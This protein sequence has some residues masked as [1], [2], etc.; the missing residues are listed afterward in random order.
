MNLQPAS[1]TRTSTRTAGRTRVLVRCTILVAWA[2]HFALGAAQAQTLV[3]DEV[4]GLRLPRNVV[5]LSYE[6][7]LTID[8]KAETF[9][10]A[11]AIKVRVDKPTDL[12]WLNAAKLTI[13]EARAVLP[14]PNA[15]GFA[16][17]VV[18]GN[19]S[20]IGLKFAQPLP[21]GEATLRIR[22]TGTFQTTSVNG[23]F[24]QK[25]RDDWYIFTHFEPLDARRA[26]PSFD[27]PDLKASWKLTLLIPEGLRAFANMPV[28]SERGSAPGWRE[29]SFLRSPPLPTY[30]IAFAVGSFDVRD[31]GTAGMNR[32]PISVITPKGRAA[33]AAYAAANTGAILAAAEKY[34][35][36]PYPFPKLDL[37]AFPQSTF[38][39]AMENAG[40][41]TYGARGLLARPDEMSTTFEQW[42]IAVT[43]HEIAHMWFGDLVTMAWWDDLWLNESFASWLG[44]RITAELKPAW[45]WNARLA[46]TRSWA[47]ATDRLTSARQVRQP[48]TEVNEVRAAFDSITYSKGQSVLTMFEDWLGPENFRDGV[49]RYLAQHE[50][51]NATADDFFVALGS[52]D[53]ALIPAFRGFVD[54][55]GIPLLDVVLNC[56][57]AP[58]IELSQQRLAP[59]GVAPMAAEPWVFPVCFEYGGAQKGIRQCALVRDARQSIP[60]KV[61]TCPQWVVANRDS[62]GYYLPRLSPALYA[63]LPKAERALGTKG[64]ASLIADTNTLARAGALGYVDALTFG[65]RHAGANEPRIALAAL[66]IAADLPAEFVAPVNAANFAAWVRKH[67][68]ARAKSVGWLPRKGEP[69]DMPELR[70]AALP[71]VAD[72][73]RDPKL[74]NEAQSLTARWLKRRNAMPPTVRRSVLTAAARTA[75]HNAP[76]LFDALLAVARASSDRNEQEDVLMALGAFLDPALVERAAALA[77]DPAIDVR[78]GTRALREALEDA[79]TRPTALLWFAQ[80][81]DVL[82]ARAPREQQG[83]WP[84]WADE[85]CTA[86]GRTQFVA[87]F[88]NRA[89]KLEAGPRSYRQ[90]L[91][92]I[93]LCLA[94]RVA[95]QASI[96]AFFAAAR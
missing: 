35:G 27:E 30:L 85:V 18:P 90:A 80:N 55:P 51:G 70:N 91:E 83:F 9:S 28:E 48:V 92:K 86:E 96:N 53:P 17:T 46:D 19:D 43:A 38:F 8:P 21:A 94:L 11:L 57:A 81:Y 54:R 47:I 36:R 56:S 95:Q 5:P 64:M 25:D 79:R 12:V 58:T 74:V 82:A 60:L 31:G 14:G 20:V 6:A 59:V 67:Y 66:A 13:E 89:A 77:L 78:L 49:R 52:A 16:A 68:S 3:Q 39:G 7:Q 37:I 61:N 4:P 44:D 69:T 10:G 65:A 76:M 42:F 45:R 63:A 22:Y 62:V 15:E 40:L 1:C 23:A 2:L 34:F 29:I 33:E 72:R 93:D 50:W 32:T 88:E 24:K 71:F 41:I 75:N 84:Y 87:M 26:F 73:G